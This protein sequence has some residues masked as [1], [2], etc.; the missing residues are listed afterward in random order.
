MGGSL[1]HPHMRAQASSLARLAQ[2]FLRP[3]HPFPGLKKGGSAP[4]PKRRLLGGGISDRPSV[5]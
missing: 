4:H 5:L 3:Q 1:Q 2:P